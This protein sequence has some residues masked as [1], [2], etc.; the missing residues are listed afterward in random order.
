M[1]KRGHSNVHAEQAEPHPNISDKAMIPITGGASFHTVRP[2]PP[3][4]LSREEWETIGERMGWLKHKLSMDREFTGT[5]E[6]K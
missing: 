5:G 4:A 6:R 2:L 1:S 3:L